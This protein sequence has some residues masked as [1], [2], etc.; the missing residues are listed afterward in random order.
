MKTA[1]HRFQTA[2]AVLA[3]SL[4]TAGSLADTFDDGGTHNITTFV[5]DT[6]VRDS[7]GGEPTTVHGR[8]GAGFTNLRVYDHSFGHVYAGAELTQ[9]VHAYDSSTIHLRGGSFLTSLVDALDTS[10]V[11]IDGGTYTASST[12]MLRGF[13][14]A[15]LVVNGGSFTNPGSGGNGNLLVLSDRAQATINGGAFFGSQMSLGGGGSGDLGALT[16]T[17][18]SFTTESGSGR[19]QIINRYDAVTTIVGSSFNL[20]F[21]VITGDFD[22]VLTGVLANGDAID[23]DL[24]QSVRN[25]SDTAHIVLSQVPE[26]GAAAL[27]L[28][29]LAAAGALRCRRRTATGLGP[30]PVAPAHVPEGSGQAS[31]SSAGARDVVVSGGAGEGVHAPTVT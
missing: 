22:G 6:W 11:I 16:I 4:A 8:A 30:R 18:G 19:M 23:I 14:D 26:P 27:M 17:G 13:G 2:A 12:Q 28:L 31:R 24:F 29:G 7:A 25:S 9:G 20:P 10:T 21:G 5:G 15:T 3:L 1:L